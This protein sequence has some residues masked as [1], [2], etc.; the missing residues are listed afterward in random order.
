MVI[1]FHTCFNISNH[2]EFDLPLDINRI[3]LFNDLEYF[4]LGCQ[5]RYLPQ[6]VLHMDHAVQHH[7]ITWDVCRAAA[8]LVLNK[9]IKS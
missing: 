4:G 1:N 7:I 5:P 8:G 3:T 2:L 6:D 9:R